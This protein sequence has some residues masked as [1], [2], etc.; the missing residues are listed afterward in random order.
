LAVC[1]SIILATTNRLAINTF[2]CI[3]DEV[4]E[5]SVVWRNV[6]RTVTPSEESTVALDGLTVRYYRE[7]PDSDDEADFTLDADRRPDETPVVLLHGGGLDSAALSWKYALP[8]LADD[9]PVYA[10]DWPGYGA[11]DPPDGSPSVDYYVEVLERFLDALGLDRVALVG[12]SMGGGAALGFA[13][14]RPERVERLVAVDSYGL[15]SRIPGGPLGAVFVRLPLVNELPFDA[16]ARSRW[17]AA[18]TLRAIVAPGNL[19]PDLV[20]DVLAELRRPRA[21]EAWTAFQ[22]NE[23]GFDGLRTDFTAR[24]PE[25]GVPTLFVHGEADP[26]VPVEWSVRAEELAPDA[27]VE[28]LRDCGHWPP[29]EKPEAFE[30]LVRRFLADA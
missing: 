12:I 2:W 30:G 19:T 11:S 25:L 28:V 29:R 6:S 14:R 24:L 17:L 20:E 7:G 26:L 4:K 3:A 22:R 27:R 18:Q 15:G 8:A 1:Q 5:S 21:G 23:V 10:L 13:L 9:R 16:M